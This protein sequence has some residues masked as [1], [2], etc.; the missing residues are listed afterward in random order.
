MITN[1]SLN[2]EAI[3]QN[4]DKSCSEVEQAVKL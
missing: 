2:V 4:P 1:E 3:I